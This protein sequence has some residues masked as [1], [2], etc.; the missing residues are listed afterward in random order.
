MFADYLTWWITGV[1]EI[2]TKKGEQDGGEEVGVKK[3]KKWN[4]RMKRYKGHRGNKLV[5]KMSIWSSH[6]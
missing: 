3:W 2:T 1:Y 6:G 4:H 5:V